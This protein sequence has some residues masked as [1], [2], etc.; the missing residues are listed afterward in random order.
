MLIPPFYVISDT[1][2]FHKNIVKFC[3]RDMNHNWIM[4]ARWNKAVGPDDTVLHLGDLLL[5]R[6]VE[7]Q[8]QFFD[9]VAPQLMGRKFLILGNHDNKRW[10]SRY[11]DA[12]FRVIRPFNMRYRG[13]DVSFDHYPTPQGLIKRSERHIRVHGHIHNSGYQHIHA[14]RKEPRRYGNVNVSV[15]AIDYTPQPIERVL[16]QAIDDFKPKQHYVN[17]NSKRNG[18]RQENRHAA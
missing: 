18:T 16:D 5:T 1:H 6:S 14:R 13:W 7:K 11:E 4:L 12:G 17:V 2:W 10:V 8:D 9:E 15:E 3:N